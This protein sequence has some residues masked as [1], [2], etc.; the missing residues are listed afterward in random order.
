MYIFICIRSMFPKVDLLRHS[1][2]N[3]KVSICGVSE[4][5][6]NEKMDSSLVD[7]KGYK[8]ERL[9]RSWH[10]G[11]RGSPKKGG[12]VCTYFRDT[13]MYSAQELSNLNQSTSYVEA[14]WF[15]IRQPNQKKIIM[16]NIYR[17]PQGQ[18]ASF[19]HYL[20]ECLNRINFNG[21]QLL[22]IMGDFNIDY[23]DKKI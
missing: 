14:Q 16:E 12:G 17:P 6:L 4:S 8:V 10:T 13:I 23:L 21:S 15:T 3:S 20:D 19:S 22:L 2:E 7:C 5:W 11:N 9:D 18:V 1:L